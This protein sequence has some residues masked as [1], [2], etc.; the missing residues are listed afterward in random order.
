MNEQK[1]FEAYR[2]TLPYNIA[3]VIYPADLPEG[4]LQ[5]WSQDRAKEERE[6]YFAAKKKLQQDQEYKLALKIRDGMVK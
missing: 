4:F 2:K 6:K 3:K 5:C 1:V